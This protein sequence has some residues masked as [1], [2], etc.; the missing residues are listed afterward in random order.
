MYSDPSDA[1][2]V[3]VLADCSSEFFV[4]MR[5]LKLAFRGR[6]NDPSP[7]HLRQVLDALL[8]HGYIEQKKVRNSRCYRVKARWEMWGYAARLEGQLK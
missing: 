7:A 6:Y 3:Q 4:P 5:R 8:Y 1:N 2:I